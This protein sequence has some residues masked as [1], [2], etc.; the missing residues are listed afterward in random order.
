MSQRFLAVIFLS[1]T[2]LS[3]ADQLLRG[4]L[5]G[6]PRSVVE[7]QQNC[8]VKPDVPFLSQY[9]EDETIYRTF[10]ANPPKCGGT[11]VEMGGLDGKSFSN[12]WFFQ[13]RYY[14]FV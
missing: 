5:S 2:A 1:I 11:V 7:K 4:G 14:F 12:S 10:F 13:V 9:L 3:S 6:D 8:Q